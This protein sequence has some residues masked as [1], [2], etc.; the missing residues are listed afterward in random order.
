L[1]YDGRVEDEDLVLLDRW[2]TGDASAGQELFAKYFEVVYRFFEHKTDRDID[3][4]VQDTFLACLAARSSFRRQ[5]KFKTFL[6]SIARNTLFGHWRRAAARGTALD[7]DEVSVASLSTSVGSRL[8]RHE[9]RA[10][11]LDALRSLPLEQQSLLEMFYWE[12]LDRDALA[13]VFEVETATIGTRLFRA[14]QTLQA[15]LHERAGIT[16]EGFDEWAKR[17]GNKP[18]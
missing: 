16:V 6:L 8:A 17:L 15:R 10:A 7:F 1:R 9:D 4:L 13:E 12:E 3:D 18:R 11:L 5:S 14:R 2:Q